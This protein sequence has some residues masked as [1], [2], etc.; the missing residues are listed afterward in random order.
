MKRPLTILTCLLLAVS[1]HAGGEDVKKKSVDEKSKKR[2]EDVGK[3]SSGE[4]DPKDGKEQRKSGLA[5]GESEKRREQIKKMSP[6]ERA[7][8]RKEIRGRLEKRIG[9]LRGR[10]ANGTLTAQEGRELERREE[11][12]KRFDVELTPRNERPKV[13][14]TNAPRRSPGKED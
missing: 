6:E 7:A 1:V 5:R 10:Q 3:P 11:I 4:R 13:V 2:Q 9:E 14:L 12:L 8:K